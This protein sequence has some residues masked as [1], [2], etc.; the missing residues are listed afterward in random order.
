MTR[1]FQEAQHGA[2]GTERPTG[3]DVDELAALICSD[4]QAAGLEIFSMVRAGADAAKQAAQAL[5]QATCPD[6][7]A[8]PNAVTVATI[9]ERRGPA[10]VAGVGWRLGLLC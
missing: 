2:S 7:N 1:P 5:K 4:Y 3:A 9:R 10:A 6:A 8:L